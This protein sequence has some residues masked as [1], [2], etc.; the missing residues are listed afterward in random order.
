MAKK[1]SEFSIQELATRLTQLV[2]NKHKFTDQYNTFVS[3][4]APLNGLNKKFK[5]FKASYLTNNDKISRVGDVIN[6]KDNNDHNNLSGFTDEKFIAYI[7]AT[8]LE[9]VKFNI[10]SY[11]IEIP[12]NYLASVKLVK[13]VLNELISIVEKIQDGVPEP[14]VTPPTPVVVHN[15]STYIDFNVYGNEEMIY[16]YY[17]GRMVPVSQL[18]S[19]STDEYLIDT[20]NIVFIP[21]LP[22]TPENVRIYH[23]VEN[24]RR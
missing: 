13:D 7:L 15:P 14:I 22:G 24:R 21:L 8:R 19:T 6:R 20:N 2:A 3:V 16:D 4:L 11:H 9:Y 18:N 10:I 1:L 5:Y 17:S 12:F 23:R